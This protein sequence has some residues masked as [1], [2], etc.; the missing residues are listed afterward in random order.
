VLPSIRR[1][2][3]IPR[4]GPLAFVAED[5]HVVTPRAVDGGIG[6]CRVG[7]GEASTFPGFC[8]E[9]EAEFA[10]IEQTKDV[11]TNR[12]WMLQFFR[13]VC[14]EIRVLNR[15][16]E[17]LR[18]L[19]ADYEVLLR[20][21]ARKALSAAVRA[22]VQVSGVRGVDWRQTV[23]ERAIAGIDELI[24]EHE[25]DFLAPLRTELSGGEVDLAAFVV[26]VDAPLPVCLAGRGNFH[27]Q[28]LD[29]AITNVPVFLQVFPTQT[30][31]KLGL[32]AAKGNADF[33][34]VYMG[35]FLREPLNPLRMVES[36]MLH[37]TDH[38]FLRPSVWQALPPE[39]QAR[40]VAEFEDG[41][42]SIGDPADAEIFDEARARYAAVGD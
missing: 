10:D 42:R 22:D 20:E 26:S 8:S 29:G 41:S 34:S 24:A 4:S 16:R 2:H 36:W 7:I 6:F 14:W 27:V 23:A 5:G 3:A 17:Y 37:G 38:W 13:T 33:L 39:R 28:T 35:A 31:T 15:I 18:Q 25:R 9:H 11:D 40:I 19:D 21:K 32:L 1:S 12:A 30:G